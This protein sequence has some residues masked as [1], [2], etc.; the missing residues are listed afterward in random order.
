MSNPEHSAR[1]V[2]TPDPDALEVAA[3]TAHEQ[4]EVLRGALNPCKMRERECAAHQRWDIRPIQ[5][6]QHVAIEAARVARRHVTIDLAWRSG[7]WFVRH[8]TLV[9]EVSRMR[10]CFARLGLAEPARRLSIRN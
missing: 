1:S 6:G 8:G 5:N 3:G 4:I 7:V 9:E 10:H 2:T